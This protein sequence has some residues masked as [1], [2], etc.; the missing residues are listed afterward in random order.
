MDGTKIIIG[1]RDR[2]DL[3]GLGYSNIRACTSG[4][5]QSEVSCGENIKEN[6]VAGVITDPFGEFC[7]QL[8]AAAS[9]CVISLNNNPILHQGD[10]IIKSALRWKKP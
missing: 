7:L 5:F 9:G 2:V 8:K 6:Q 10:T 3:P 1:R 4:I